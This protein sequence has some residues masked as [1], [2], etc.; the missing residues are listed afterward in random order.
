M[1]KTRQSVMMQ[2]LDI[3]KFPSYYPN[4]VKIVYPVTSKKDSE[5]LDSKGLLPTSKFMTEGPLGFL[6]PFEKEAIDNNMV[7][8]SFA[9]DSQLIS[10]E[11][12]SFYESTK[13]NF[14]GTSKKV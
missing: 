2:I 13:T 4:T 9:T 3:S 8:E 11:T 1:E 14:K 7:Y 12:E 5:T 10:F 6:Y